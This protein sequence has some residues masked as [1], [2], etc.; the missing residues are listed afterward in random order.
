MRSLVKEWLLKESLL[1]ESLSKEVALAATSYRSSG[2]REPFVI[3]SWSYERQHPA[4]VAL[5]Q[6]VGKPSPIVGRQ[7]SRAL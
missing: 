5:P 1:R 6:P 3:W 4:L 2:N 7:R